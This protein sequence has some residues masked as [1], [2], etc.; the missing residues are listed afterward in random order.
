MYGAIKSELIRIARPSFLYGGLGIIAGFA[1]LVTIFVFTSAGD[2]GGPL[3]AFPSAA[4]LAASDGFVATLTTLS[5]LV[6]VVTLAFWAIAVATDYDTGLV[7]LL[8][9][10][11]PNRLRLLAGKVGALALFTVTST[12]LATLVATLTAYPMAWVADVSTAAWGADMFVEFLAA[13]G[14][15]TLAALV[16]GAVGLAIAV[17]TRS[18]GTAIAAGIGYLLVVEN[19]LGIVAEDVVDYLPGGILSAVAAGG[20]ATVAYGTALALA[21]VYGLTAIGSSAAIFRRREIVS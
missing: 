13:W 16:W 17:A 19:L 12:F 21:A 1:S 6:G 20:T 7:R 8:T 18:A 10:A 5:G 14:N 9:Q 3:R 4:E 2:A 11:E 15:L